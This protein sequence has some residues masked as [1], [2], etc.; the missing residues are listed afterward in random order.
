MCHCH[1][2]CP[3]LSAISAIFAI[4]AIPAIGPLV[5]LSAS[6]AL[7]SPTALISPILT[8]CVRKSGIAI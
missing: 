6:R 8:S 4:F 2:F 5:C 3:L 7:P 1:A